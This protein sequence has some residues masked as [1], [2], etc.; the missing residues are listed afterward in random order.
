MNYKEKVKDILEECLTERGFKLWKGVDKILP[1]VWNKPTSSTGKYH[2]KLDG[3]VPDQAEH[4]YQMLYAAKK[5]IRLFGYEPKSV[6]ADVIFLAIAFHDSLKYGKFGT[7]KHTDYNHDKNAAD[8][9]KYNENTFLKIFDEEQAATLQEAVRF[10]SGRWSTDV[11]NVEKFDWDRSELKATTF[12][13]HLLDMM[14]TADLIQTDIRDNIN[15]VS[16]SE[17]SA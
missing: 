6:N 1:D 3:T 5:I 11:G 10:H 4:I 15:D 2:K 16:I 9:I 14:S 7:N 17:A 12:F 8:M 13:I